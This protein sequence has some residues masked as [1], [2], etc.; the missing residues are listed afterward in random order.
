M[1]TGAFLLSAVGFFTIGTDASGLSTL[2]RP[3][4]SPMYLSGAEH[5]FKQ[6]AHEFANTNW[7]NEVVANLKAW[8]VTSLG[9]GPTPSLR[10]RGLPYTQIAW[11]SEAMTTSTNEDDFVFQMKA[12]LPFAAGHGFCAMPPRLWSPS[13]I[14]RLIPRRSMTRNAVRGR[15][16]RCSIR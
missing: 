7:E 8:H 15:M 11:I 9:A 2:V 14:R 12:V 1:M 4:G 6:Q 16:R 10:G 13:R 5:L 3:D